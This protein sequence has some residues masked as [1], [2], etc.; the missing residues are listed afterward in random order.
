M[1]LRNT[2]AAT[3][4]SVAILGM[5]GAAFAKGPDQIMQ[6]HPPKMEQKASN[7]AGHK[8]VAPQKHKVRFIRVKSGDS[9]SKIAVKYRTSVS[10]LKRLNHLRSDKIY[11]GQRLRI[12]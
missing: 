3:L 10:H 7:K 6:Q 11:A 5:S 8:Q 9:L 4:V 2:V 1:K 12:S